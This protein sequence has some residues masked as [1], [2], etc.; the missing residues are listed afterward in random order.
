MRSAS[1]VLAVIGPTFAPGTINQDSSLLITRRG[2]SEMKTTAA[3]KIKFPIPLSSHSWPR[4]QNSWGDAGPKKGDRHHSEM[5]PVCIQDPSATVGE[6]HV[7]GCASSGFCGV[8][9]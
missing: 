3:T 5:E 8:G 7:R 4:D 6:M 2:M 9:R 1:L